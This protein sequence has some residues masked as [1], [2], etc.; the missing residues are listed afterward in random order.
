MSNLQTIAK[1]F[2]AVAIA[3]ET[4]EHFST[5]ENRYSFARVE[6]GI[7]IDTRK[8]RFMLV[9]CAS[10]RWECRDLVSGIVRSA[11]TARDAA[12][13]ANKI[14]RSARRKQIAA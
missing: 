6:A 9:R 12:E 13:L 14:W 4:P 3:D 8:A 11:E 2:V 7:Y 5:Y 1:S 10:H